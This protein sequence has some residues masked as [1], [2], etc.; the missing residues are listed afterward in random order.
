MDHGGNELVDRSCIITVQLDTNVYITM[1]WMLGII[2]RRIR[3]L[4]FGRDPRSPVHRTLL[5]GRRRPEP[6]EQTMHMKD[7]AT[8][9]PNQRA[10]V[11]GHLARRTA[12]FVG[13]AADSTDVVSVDTPFPLRHGIPF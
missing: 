6:L 11:P 3:H 9:A 1:L 12:A 8:L 10:V 5:L 13:N 2:R 7:M 4:A